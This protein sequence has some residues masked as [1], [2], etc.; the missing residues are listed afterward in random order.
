[1]SAFNRRGSIHEEVSLGS[2]SDI[3]P[4]PRSAGVPP[5][6]RLTPRYVTAPRLFGRIKQIGTFHPYEFQVG[7]V[8]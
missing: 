6:K 7:L 3:A 4:V 1:M 2:G 8:N 5:M